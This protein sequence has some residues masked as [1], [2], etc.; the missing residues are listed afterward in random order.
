MSKAALNAL[1]KVIAEQFGAAD[2]RAITISPGPVKTGV[3]TDTDGFIARIATRNGAEHQAL[4]DELL[5][6]IGASTGR[7]RTPAEVARLIAVTA[8]PNNIN[9]AEYLIDGG[10]KNV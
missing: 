6:N 3:W 7:I 9:G 10:V 4:A 1:T 5:S 2:V 8:S